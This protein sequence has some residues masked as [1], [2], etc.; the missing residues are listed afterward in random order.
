LEVLAVHTQT[1]MYCNY[2]NMESRIMFE[3]LKQENQEK[4]ENYS[5]TE[6]NKAKG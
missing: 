3:K 1:R 4:D 5:V 6:L 2:Y